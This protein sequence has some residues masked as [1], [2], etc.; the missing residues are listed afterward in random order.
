ME[1]SQLGCGLG[2][3]F[4]GTSGR[5]SLSLCFLIG[6]VG[7]RSVCDVHKGAPGTWKVLVKCPSLPFPWRRRALQAGQGPAAA[8]DH[9]EG[10]LGMG[11]HVRGAFPRDRAGG[12][13]V[14]SELDSDC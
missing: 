14:G 2:A 7:L 1:S 8:L 5:P 13:R 11:E 12:Q 6:K 10:V 3:V 4:L 9:R